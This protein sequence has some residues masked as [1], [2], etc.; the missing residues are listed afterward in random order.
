MQK[1]LGLSRPKRKVSTDA[2]NKPGGG[3]K[4]IDDQ[5][6]MSRFIAAR[7]FEIGIELFAAGGAGHKHP[8]YVFGKT[9]P[10][11][12]FRTLHFGMVNHGL[13]RK[14]GNYVTLQPPPRKELAGR[15]FFKERNMWRQ[16]GLMYSIF[17]Q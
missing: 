1:E 15:F 10:L 7:Q 9:Q 13:V 12:T 11:A 4:D 3:L 5:G 6:S 2:V 8:A 16:H 14:S 17:R